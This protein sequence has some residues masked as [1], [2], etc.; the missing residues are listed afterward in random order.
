MPKTILLIEDNED[1]RENTAELL[2]LEGFRVL[3]VQNGQDGIALTRTD[4]PD[5]VICD[6]LM[7]EMDGYAVFRR[8]LSQEE[9]RHIP[10]IFFTARSES[11]DKAKA[12]AIGRCSYLIKPFDETELLALIAR[13]LNGRAE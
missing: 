2:E 8:L 9:T 10:F 5:L 6:I 12:D 11:V 4:L 3:A 1:I 7:P 13:V